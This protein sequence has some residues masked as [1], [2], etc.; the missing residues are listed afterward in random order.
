MKTLARPN[1]NRKLPMITFNDGKV[2][3]SE[4][5]LTGSLLQSYLNLDE[6]DRNLYDECYWK[7]L[8]HTSILNS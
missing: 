4:L 5:A 2:Q 8:I 6:R 7:L 1:R 3:V